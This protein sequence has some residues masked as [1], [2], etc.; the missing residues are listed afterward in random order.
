MLDIAADGSRPI[1]RINVIARS[2]IEPTDSFNDN[3][4]VVNEN[5]GDKPNESFC[6][7]SNDNFGDDS[8]NGHDPSLDV[9]DQPVDAED[10]EHFEE[11]DGEPELRSQPNHSFSDRTNFYMYQTFSTKSELQLLLAEATARKS[12]DFS[13]VKS[14]D[15]L[16]LYYNATK[17]YSLEEFNNHFLEF[18]DISPEA[19]FFLEHDVGFEKWSRTHFPGNMYDVMTT[20]IA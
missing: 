13:T 16:Y 14:C 2:P 8:M 11:Y 1:L 5:L 10:F 17:A 12:F 15:S 4:S 6:D 9:E 18:K 19:T 7:Q 3:D 20:N